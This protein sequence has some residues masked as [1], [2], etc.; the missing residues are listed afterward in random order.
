[1]TELHVDLE[2]MRASGG[3]MRDVGTDFAA[4]LDAFR[5]RIA[6]YE[7]A[8]G[9]DTIGTL[10]GTAYQ[11]FSDWT[12]QCWGTMAEEIGY[13]GEDIVEMARTVEQADDDAA[14]GLEAIAGRLA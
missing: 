13:A 1:M 6:A 10:V 9:H 12:F 5:G 4:K 11:Y 7:G 8:W 2:A 3:S 14:A